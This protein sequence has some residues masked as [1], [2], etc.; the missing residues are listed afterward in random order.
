[1][2]MLPENANGRGLAS[3][4]STTREVILKPADPPRDVWGWRVSEKGA[5]H[6]LQRLWGWRSGTFAVQQWRFETAGYGVNFAMSLP[7]RFQTQ[8]TPSEFEAQTT[9]ASREMAMA[10]VPSPAWPTVRSVPEEEL[11]SPLCCL[12]SA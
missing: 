7:S 1:M 12:K 11:C 8:I 5:P 3:E 9:P 10:S 6:A 4:D 2:A